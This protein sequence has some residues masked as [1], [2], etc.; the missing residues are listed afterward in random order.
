MV[1]L[2]LTQ[3]FRSF[4]VALAVVSKQR[5][6]QTETMQR[7]ENYQPTQGVLKVKTLFT[8][9]SESN[10]LAKSPGSLKGP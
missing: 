1:N 3:D 10:P 9:T 7:E 5:V 4:F 2:V 6:L 8:L